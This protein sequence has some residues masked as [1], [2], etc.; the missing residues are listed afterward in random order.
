M[1]FAE[2]V[3]STS[4]GAS[5]RVHAPAL[6]LCWGALAADPHGG[7]TSWLGAPRGLGVARP[8]VF[9]H[10][11]FVVCMCVCGRLATCR[12]GPTD[13]MSCDARE[14][15]KHAVAEFAGTTEEPPR[16]RM[17]ERLERSLVRAGSAHMKPL[18]Q[19]CPGQQL[20]SFSLS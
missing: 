8:S 6:A 3:A 4:R 20:G 1:H 17:R 14:V 9:V 18:R 7:E 11:C 19:P 16:A 2:M 5:L 15:V 12:S 10:V 13:A